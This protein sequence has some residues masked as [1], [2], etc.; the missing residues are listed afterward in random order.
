MI[1]YKNKNL[2]SKNIRNSYILNNTK[3]G[4]KWERGV[5]VSGDSM[6]NSP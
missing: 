2:L 1:L 3:C 4:E 6:E 5:S